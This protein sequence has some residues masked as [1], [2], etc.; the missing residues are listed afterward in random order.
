MLLPLLDDAEGE[1]RYPGALDNAGTLQLDRPRAEMLEQPDAVPEQDRHEVHVYLV[2]D[3][4][5]EA[6]LRDAGRS[7]GDVSL[8]AA[9]LAFSTARSTPSVTN[10]NGDP[11]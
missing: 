2:E 3:S 5:P 7:D 1:V 11:S 10:W 8:T 6:L 9:A 4:R